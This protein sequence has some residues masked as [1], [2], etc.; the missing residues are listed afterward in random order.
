MNRLSKTTNY[1]VDTA[2]HGCTQLALA[3]S[4]CSYV[5]SLGLMHTSIFLET[6]EIENK[7]YEFDSK[8]FSN[9]FNLMIASAVSLCFFTVIGHCISHPVRRQKLLIDTFLL[10]YS[11]LACFASACSL[12]FSTWHIYA[13]K[14]IFYKKLMASFNIDET[15]LTEEL[16]IWGSSYFPEKFSKFFSFTPNL[17]LASLVSTL[18][19]MISWSC[20][21]CSVGSRKI[22]R[23][24]LPLAKNNKKMCIQ[25]EE[26]NRGL[27][28]E[29]LLDQTGHQPQ[30]IPSTWLTAPGI[31][32]NSYLYF[33]K[34]NSNQLIQTN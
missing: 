9:T 13:Y 11:Q 4:A 6:L 33:P 16:R 34:S 23:E 17:Q 22:E 14:T 21:Y 12:G 30:A 31:E 5:F 32:D 18:F 25:K 10:R 24:S 8:H 27:L 2:L 20:V 15:L 19:F 1:V 7:F 26:L 3:A 28:Q 29:S